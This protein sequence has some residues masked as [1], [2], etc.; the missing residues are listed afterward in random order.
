MLNLIKAEPKNASTDHKIVFGYTIP[1]GRHPLT[2]AAAY[3]LQNYVSTPS[4]HQNLSNLSRTLLSGYPVLLQGPTSAGKTSM[5]EYMA[6]LTGNRFVR[7]NN[8]EHTDLQEYIGS[9]SWSDAENRIKFQEGVLVQA[10]RNGWWIVLDELNLAPTDVLEALNRLLDD[11][12]ELFIAETG[13][14]VTPAEGFMLFATQNPAGSV[15]GGR[16]FLSRAFRN[17]FV[18]VHFGSIPSDELEVI[19]Q[20]RCRIAPSYARKM[21]SVFS[22]LQKQRSKS[23]IFDAREG[24]MTLRDLFRWAGRK[25]DGGEQPIGDDGYMLLAERIRTPEERET[26]VNTL[27]KFLK[28]KIDVDTIYYSAQKPDAGLLPFPIV[29]TKAMKRLYALVC[30]ALDHSE[31]VLLVGETGCGKTTVLQV[32]AAAHRQRIHIVNCHEHSEPADFIGS[33]RP[34][35]SDDGKLFEWTNGPLVQAM[36]NGDVFVLDEISLAEDS[37]LERLNSVLEPSQLLVLAEKSAQGDVEEINGAPGF[38]ICASM[39]PGGDFGK[40]E[41]SPALRNRFTEIWVGAAW[42]DLNDVK[43]IINDR[44]EIMD[45]SLATAIILQFCEFFA[46]NVLQTT[47]TDIWSGDE[48]LIGMR[49]IL[50]WICFIN[51]SKL[52]LEYS[53]YHGCCMTMIDSIGMNQNGFNRSASGQFEVASLKDSCTQFILNLV[54][55]SAAVVTDFNFSLV[56]HLKI[57][58]FE[59]ESG[60]VQT[61]TFDNFSFTTEGTRRNVFSVIRAMQISQKKPI[62]LEGA[63]GVGKTSLVDAIAKASKHHLVRINLSEQTDIMDL[64]GSDVPVDG[65]SSQAAMFQWRNGPFLNAMVSGHWVL[66]DELNLANQSVLE[67]LN[68]CFDHRASV[69]IPELDRTFTRHSEFRVFA[70]QN[71]IGQ[72]GGRKGLPKS[73]L[74]RFVR[75]FV[76]VLSEED[77]LKICTHSFPKMETATLSRMIKFNFL[78]YEKTMVDGAFGQIGKPWEFNL[79]DMFRWVSLLQ[80][81]PHTKP[82]DF[83]EIMYLHRMRTDA[84]RKTVVELFEKVAESSYIPYQRQITWSMSASEFAIGTAVLSRNSISQTDIYNMRTTIFASTIHQLHSVAKC[85]EMRWMPILVGSAGCGKTSLVRFLANSTGRKLIEMPM[86]SSTDSADLI[87]GFEQASVGRHIQAF[88]VDLEQKAIDHVHRLGQFEV[89]EM[90]TTFKADPRSNLDT[91]SLILNNLGGEQ[92]LLDSLNTLKKM[93]SEELKA[94]GSF[95]WVDG[96]L[97]DAVVNGHWILIDNANLC[98]PS[99]LDRLNSLV[100]SQTFFFVGERSRNSQ[101]DVIVPHKNFRIFLSVDPSRGGELS[102]AMRN[103]GIEICFDAL[104]AE[105]QDDVLKACSQ[106]GMSSRAFAAHF[107]CCRSNDTASLSRCVLEAALDIDSLQRDVN[108]SSSHLASELQISSSWPQEMSPTLLTNAD[109]TSVALTVKSFDFLSNTC[110]TDMVLL[111]LSTPKFSQDLIIRQLEISGADVASLEVVRRCILYC[112]DNI[113]DVSDKDA[114]SSFVRKQPHGHIKLL[115][116]QVRFMLFACNFSKSLGVNALETSCQRQ[117]I[118]SFTL[119]ETLYCSSLKN[120]PKVFRDTEKSFLRGIW[121]QI[122]ELIGEVTAVSVNDSTVCSWLHVLQLTLEE[123]YTQDFTRILSCL[124]RLPSIMFPRAALVAQKLA[125]DQ[126]RLERFITLWSRS[127]SHHIRNNRKLFD[128]VVNLIDLRDG[129]T[130]YSSS[131]ASLTEDTE[132]LLDALSNTLELS[133]ESSNHALSTEL[134]DQIQQFVNRR[135]ELAWSLFEKKRCQSLYNKFALILEHGFLASKSKSDIQLF[136]KI[137]GMSA[138]KLVDLVPLHKYLALHTEGDF[139]MSLRSWHERVWT[140][141]EEGPRYLWDSSTLGFACNLMYVY[142]GYLFLTYQL[143]CLNFFTRHNCYD[144]H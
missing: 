26:V 142:F 74:N 122:V 96:S 11:N 13:E 114:M 39:N 104:M 83:L 117:R 137:Y 29:W 116:N 125:A 28:C 118:Q 106:L 53:T 90:L 80:S 75:V 42:S 112:R 58:P 69:Y 124:K 8:H 65:N 6:A 121:T 36:L 98:S 38:K 30:R 79:R 14:T 70:A 4:V 89:L 2:P 123:P 45:T 16:K 100:E 59:I 109:M 136:Y 52:P 143:R 34:K 62:L 78:L 48:V 7:I 73:F 101:D 55:L 64:F 111:A 20:S 10:L 138:M 87:G 12:R 132:S 24:F 134:H 43:L 41:L 88:I 95:E 135:R 17:R 67:G 3:L 102:R 129:S 66:L 94:M 22:S 46:R 72:G 133:F 47:V 60:T 97:V 40:K 9:Y 99:V 15:Y 23:R 27:E 86:N 82:S 77:L 57:G 139:L 32:F 61:E 141:M 5:I 119:A 103:R 144:D 33:I 140:Y 63:P 128:Q 54:G 51:D 92:R 35:R 120:S 91:A 108:C 50:S 18:E 105:S 49:D 115:I 31:P 25:N 85:V 126:A 81:T 21:V 130:F 84:D 71:P 127:L 68:A 56:P 1:V 19:L 113:T 76:D 37:V 93:V 110:D 44:L 107:V 131:E